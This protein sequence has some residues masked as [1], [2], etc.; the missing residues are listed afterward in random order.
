LIKEVGKYIYLGSEIN[1]ELKIDREI[2][3]TIQNNSAFYYIILWNKEKS[4]QCQMPIC[5]ICFKP[6]LPVMLKHGLLQR[7]MKAK[8]EQ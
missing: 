4:K 3:R 7:K 5:K 1:S 8:A 6:I 2:S